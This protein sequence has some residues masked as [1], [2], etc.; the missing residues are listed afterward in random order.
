MNED[1]DKDVKDELSPHLFEP[2][3]KNQD[4]ISHIS[5]I[6]ISHDPIPTKEACSSDNENNEDSDIDCASA[7]AH[8]DVMYVDDSSSRSL[9]SNEISDLLSAEYIS[10]HIH[11]VNKSYTLLI[12]V[13]ILKM[14]QRICISLNP[15]V[16]KI[17]V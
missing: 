11:P 4:I 2:V 16:R 5:K 8:E 13:L 17:R 14:L 9:S 15:L 6:E 1:F 12:F 7:Y 3:L 10:V